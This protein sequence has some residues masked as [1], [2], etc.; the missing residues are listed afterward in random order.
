MPGLSVQPLMQGRVQ[1]MAGVD[2]AKIIASEPA[3]LRI[4]DTLADYFSECLH[5][6]NLLFLRA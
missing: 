2:R 6:Y 4:S 5:P 3:F 1:Q